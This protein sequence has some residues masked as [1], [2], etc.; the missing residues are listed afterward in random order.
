[1]CGG[2]SHIAIQLVLGELGVE[3]GCGR[4]SRSDAGGRA[5]LCRP[6]TMTVELA[7]AG[8]LEATIAST[9]M[10][11]RMHREVQT[12]PVSMN[13]RIRAELPEAIQLSSIKPATGAL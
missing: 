4:L 7:H 2:K 5:A 9:V 11:V 12:A 6:A 8:R 3:G 10:V 13:P 1:M